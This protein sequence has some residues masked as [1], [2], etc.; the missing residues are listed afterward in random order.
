MSLV[1]FAEKAQGGRLR[2]AGHIE[3]REEDHCC[4]VAR[5]IKFDNKRRK[6]RP[7]LRWQDK[8]KADLKEHKIELSLAADRVKW[9]QI[10]AKPDLAEA[11]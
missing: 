4:K 10:T 5:G 6:G 11:G 3:R 8:I 7:Y 2:W 9:R 1:S